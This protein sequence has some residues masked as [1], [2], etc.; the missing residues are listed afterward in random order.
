MLSNTGV[1]PHKDHCEYLRDIRK[2]E[3][4]LLLRQRELYTISSRSNITDYDGLVEV[5]KRWMKDI[6][7]VKDRCFLYHGRCLRFWRFKRLSDEINDYP[8]LNVNVVKRTI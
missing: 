1:C 8:I 4:E 2:M 3:K 7:H 6:A 5:F